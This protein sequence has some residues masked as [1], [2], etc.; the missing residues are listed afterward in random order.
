VMLNNKSNC[1]NLYIFNK[2]GK[3]L[4]MNL[5]VLKTL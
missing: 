3:P 5:M 2:H 1:K 4:Q